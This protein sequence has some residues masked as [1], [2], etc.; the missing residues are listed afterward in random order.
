[1]NFKQIEAFYWL[2][3]LHSYQQVANHIGLT[4]PA[5]SARIAALEETLNAQLIDRS[6]SGF[7]LTEQGHQVAEYAEMVVNLNEAMANRLQ[8]GRKHRFAIGMVGIVAMSWGIALRRKLAEWDPGLLVDFHS[9]SNTELQRLLRSGVLDIAFLTEEASLP[10]LPNSFSVKYR[11]GWLASPGFV[12]DISREWAP[13]ELRELP[14]ILYPRTSPIFDMVAKFL[15]ESQVRPNDRH[16]GNSLSTICDM[17]RR[18]YGVA[19][20]SLAVVEADLKNGSMVE[21]PTT[22]PFAPLNIH[23][24]HLNNARK[25]QTRQI[26]DLAEEAAR[27]WC[28]SHPLYMQFDE[29]A[30]V[31]EDQ[32]SEKP[33]AT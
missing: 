7:A 31:D 17:I 13:E 6:I 14:V 21:I 25:T 29:G 24:V 33:R 22:V 16:V 4:Q 10:R 30:A 9:A 15:R 5:V 12:D 19:P 11:L 28:A 8:E 18:G 27:E 2:T 1:M 23:C 26:Y 20:V 32:L 3:Q